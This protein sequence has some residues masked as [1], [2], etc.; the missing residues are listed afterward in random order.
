MC[1]GVPLKIIVLTEKWLPCVVFLQISCLI[2]LF[3]PLHTLNLQIIT[4]CG[5]SNVFL[6]LEIIKKVQLCI[7]VLTTYRFG[8]LAMVWGMAVTAPLGFVE[9]AWYNKKLIKYSPCQQIV[10]ILPIFCIGIAA[11]MLTWICVDLCSN[12]WLK[13]FTGTIVFSTIYILGSLWFKTVPVELFDYFS[14]SSFVPNRIR[15]YFSIKSKQ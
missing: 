11:T 5:K 14:S 3:L 7:V 2:C 6:Y 9:N 13:I 8:V 4:A 12:N 1:I 10:D 15:A